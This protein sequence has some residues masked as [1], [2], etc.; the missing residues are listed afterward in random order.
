[1]TR[2]QAMLDT[3]ALAQDRAIA[4]AYIDDAYAAMLRELLAKVERQQDLIDEFRRRDE[5]ATKVIERYRAEVERL[6]AN[7]LPCDGDCDTEGAPMAQEVR[8]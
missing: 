4:H 6:T 8:A 7:A 5:A 2:T 1:M 3:I